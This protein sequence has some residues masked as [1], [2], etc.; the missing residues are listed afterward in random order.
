ME[1]PLGI[2]VCDRML[3]MENTCIQLLVRKDVLQ[4]FSEMQK[5]LKAMVA[6]KPTPDDLLKMGICDKNKL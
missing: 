1:E 2:G 3:M 4:F 5:R 6:P